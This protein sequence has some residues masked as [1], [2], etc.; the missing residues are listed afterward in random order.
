MLLHGLQTI[1]LKPSSLAGSLNQP[2]RQAPTVLPYGSRVS[3]AKHA[4]NFGDEKNDIAMDRTSLRGLLLRT[5]RDNECILSWRINCWIT[6]IKNEVKVDRKR[7]VLCR[8]PCNNRSPLQSVEHS[9]YRSPSP[10]R[11]LYYSTY[12]FPPLER[13]SHG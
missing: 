4:Y 10:S 11:L 8:N 6:L 9:R 1:F 12:F 3:A 2:S 5:E 7:I 13:R